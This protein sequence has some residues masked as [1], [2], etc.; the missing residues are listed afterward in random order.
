[1]MLRAVG[2]PCAGECSIG[3]ERAQVRRTVSAVVPRGAL[4][5]GEHILRFEVPHSLRRDLRGA[6]KIDGT[7]ATSI[8]SHLTSATELLM[9]SL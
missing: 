9:P 4:G 1:M 8:P 6:G 5:S 7:H 2:A 3:M